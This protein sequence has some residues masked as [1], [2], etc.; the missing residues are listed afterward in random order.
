MIWVLL[1]LTICKYCSMGIKNK[2]KK[3]F[4]FM[5]TINLKNKKEHKN[6]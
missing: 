6:L 3:L 5:V 1:N 2:N 4:P